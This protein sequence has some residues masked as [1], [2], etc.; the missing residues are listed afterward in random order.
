MSVALATPLSQ[1]VLSPG[2]AM[3]VSGLSWQHY[4]LFLIELR[5]TSTDLAVVKAVRQFVAAIT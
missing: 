1:I 2:S 4:Q 5:E 3:T